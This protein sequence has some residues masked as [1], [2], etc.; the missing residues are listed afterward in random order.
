MILILADDFSGAAELAGVAAQAGWSATVQSSLVIKSHS[1][2]VAIDT[3]SRGISTAEAI[4]RVRSAYQ[5]TKDLPL[6]WSF[7][8][9]DSVLRGHVREEFVA[10]AK[11]AGKNRILFIPANPGKGRIISGGIYLIDNRPLH[12]TA[13]AQDPDFP[14][15]TSSVTEIIGND[16]NLP[17]RTILTTEPIPPRGL[18]I[19]DV[20]SAADIAN[21]IEE[22]DDSTL[23][24]GAA[25]FFATLLARD[26]HPPSRATPIPRRPNPAP[27]TRLFIC[28]SLAAWQNAISD[29]AESHHIPLFT[30]QST[31]TWIENA[32]NALNTSQQCLLAIGQPDTDKHSS[33]PK[34]DSLS[35]LAHLAET[36]VSVIRKARP[37]EICLEGGATATAILDKFSWTHF[38][39]LP[40]ESPEAGCLRPRSGTYRPLLFVKPGSYPWPETVWHR[41]PGQKPTLFPR[42]DEPN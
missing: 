28:G 42:L 1:D 21:R 33:V 27:K 4:H 16:P 23:C 34:R 26:T 19:P 30:F 9:T 14:R 22:I 7:K 25:E 15:D 32:I 6:R 36:A 12:E 17:T 10:L 24:G 29:D 2:V 31:A 3:K 40:S 35:L 41:F 20:Q 5:A 13:F 37:E 18:L 38:E 39:A 8:K 11:V